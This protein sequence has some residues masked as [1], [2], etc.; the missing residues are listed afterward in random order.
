MRIGRR[1]WRTPSVTKV[2]IRAVAVVTLVLGV[3]E[4]D[5]VENKMA[6]VVSETW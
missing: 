6:M 1:R 4:E 5:V 3:A 2:E